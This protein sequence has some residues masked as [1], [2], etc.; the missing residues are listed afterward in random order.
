MGEPFQKD[1][2]SRTGLDKTESTAFQGFRRQKCSWVVCLLF[3][4]SEKMSKH[5]SFKTVENGVG[6]GLNLDN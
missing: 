3:V 1:Q 5:R 2:N 4:F 6:F